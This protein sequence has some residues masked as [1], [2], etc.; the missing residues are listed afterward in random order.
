M[1]SLQE[2][3]QDELGA[4]ATRLFDEAIMKDILGLSTKPEEP[5]YEGSSCATAASKYKVT[6]QTNHNDGVAYFT[7]LEQA[8]AYHKSFAKG[9]ANLYEFYERKLS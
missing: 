8:E 2:A 1:K 3:Y 6:Y 9:G 5:V 4:I 7:N